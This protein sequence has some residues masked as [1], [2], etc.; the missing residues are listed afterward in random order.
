MKTLVTSNWILM[1]L[2]ATL[3]TSF[4]AWKTEVDF[5][6]R[7]DLTIFTATWLCLLLK[8]KNRYL[9]IFNLPWTK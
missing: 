4:Q 3:T 8:S 7:T 9:I 5:L 6:K 1:K 2:T